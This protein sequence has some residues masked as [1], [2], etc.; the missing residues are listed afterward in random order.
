MPLEQLAFAPSSLTLTS[1]S[2]YGFVFSQRSFGGLLLCLRELTGLQEFS[3]EGNAYIKCNRGALLVECLD[4]PGVSLGMLDMARLSGPEL[5][6]FDLGLRAKTTVQLLLVS[7]YR[8]SVEKERNLLKHALSLL[9]RRAISPGLTR[10]H[11]VLETPVKKYL[12][13]TVFEYNNSLV[14]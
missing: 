3:A 1:F 10:C 6:T 2:I 5:M 9:E 12:A 7:F 4:F 13:G 14:L 11:K 8:F